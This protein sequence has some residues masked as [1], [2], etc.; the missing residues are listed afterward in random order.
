M[1]T[2]RAAIDRHSCLVDLDVNGHAGYGEKG[3][4]IVCSAVTVLS[5]TAGRI[6]IS[7]FN[8]NCT[9]ESAERGS[10]KLKLGKIDEGKREWT[11]GVTEFLLNGLSDLEKE[12]PA[13]I[14]LE[15]ISNEE[16]I[17]GS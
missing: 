14:K 17:H 8:K 1:I 9:F 7:Q 10:F 4:D 3:Y 5:R 6:L 2:A 16:M 13:C 11:E 12:Y 15:I